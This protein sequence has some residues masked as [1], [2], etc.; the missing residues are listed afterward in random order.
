MGTDTLEQFTLFDMKEDYNIKEGDETKECR[1]CK[2]IKPLHL[3]RDARKTLKNLVG[4]SKRAT[5]SKCDSYNSKISSALKILHPMPT[6]DTYACPI[7]TKTAK[8]LSSNG[9]WRKSVWCLDHCHIT[10]K[11]RGWICQSC[12]LGLSRFYDSISIFKR[13]IKYLEGKL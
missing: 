3:F 1:Q 4:E 12:N 6:S 7:C 8:E 5:C 13:G 10:N 11:F 9:R 2:K